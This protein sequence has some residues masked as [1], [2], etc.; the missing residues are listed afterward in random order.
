MQKRKSGQDVNLKNTDH[1][2]ERYDEIVD[3][4]LY[5]KQYLHYFTEEEYIEDT[6]TLN[7]DDWTFLQHKKINT[8]PTEEDFENT[9]KEFLAWKVS[10]VLKEENNCLGKK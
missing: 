5:G 2:V 4:V 7:G 3:L 10:E 6:I 1:A 9:V 8:N